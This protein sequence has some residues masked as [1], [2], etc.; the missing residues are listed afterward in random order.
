VP[1]GYDLA[2][3]GGGLAANGSEAA[4]VRAIFELFV[5]KRSLAE[6][7]EELS[8]RGWTTKKL[9]DGTGPRASRPGLHRRLAHAPARE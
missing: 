7:L 4:R 9:E 1:L 8:R 3:V 2:A 6:T 5:E